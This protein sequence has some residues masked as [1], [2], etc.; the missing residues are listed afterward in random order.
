MNEWDRDNLAFILKCN[1]TEFQ[2]W[3]QTVSNDD[4]NY[5]LEL[6]ARHRTELLVAEQELRDTQ[7]ID[8]TE[9]LA[10]INRVKEKL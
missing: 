9:A 2:D 10:F 8:C 3:M 1:D 5:A 4:V 6:L 7:E